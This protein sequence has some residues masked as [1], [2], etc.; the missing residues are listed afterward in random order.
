LGVLDVVGLAS[1]VRCLYHSRFVYFQLNARH[2]E[3]Y[4]GIVFAIYLK[5]AFQVDLEIV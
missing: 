4:P 5:I 1:V 2:G 3:H